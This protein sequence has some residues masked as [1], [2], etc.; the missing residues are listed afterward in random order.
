MGKVLIACEESQTVC[1]AFRERGHEAY[2]CDI[3]EPSGGH[4]EWHIHGD[5]S[6]AERAKAEVAKEKL[7][8]ALRDALKE[9]EIGRG[10]EIPVR[11]FDEERLSM[12]EA[13]LIVRETL[14]LTKSSEVKV[15]CERRFEL[16]RERASKEHEA[17]N[18]LSK[19]IAALKKS[20]Q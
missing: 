17:D 4:P 1:K 3:Q 8:I 13:I 16:S 12:E 10:K 19:L 20:E 7:K 14:S 5:A 11:R 15:E 6:T 2:S 18:R 9:P